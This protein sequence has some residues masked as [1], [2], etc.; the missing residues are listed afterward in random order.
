MYTDCKIFAEKCYFI[1]I[2]ALCPD[3]PADKPHPGFDM[4]I[5]SKKVGLIRRCLQYFV[6]V[7]TDIFVRHTSI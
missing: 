7:C 6:Y 1:Q 4:K 5:L 3:V 2:T